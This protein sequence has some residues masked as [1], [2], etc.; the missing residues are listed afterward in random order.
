[1]A[2]RYSSAR[3][4]AWSFALSSARREL[5]ESGSDSYKNDARE[6]AKACMKGR[7]GGHQ[8][9]ELKRRNAVG[10]ERVCR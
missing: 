1:M 4:A 7:S 5:A 3:C 9:H 6:V 8:R 10:A 2:C